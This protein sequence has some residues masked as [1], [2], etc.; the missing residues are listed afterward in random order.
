MEQRETI[1]VKQ[2]AEI[3]GCKQP[4]VHQYLHKGALHKAP[5]A[6]NNGLTHVFYDEV[7]QL[8]EKREA[9]KEHTEFGRHRYTGGPG[10]PFDVR[11][12]LDPDDHSGLIHEWYI[13]KAAFDDIN[14]GAREWGK[15]PPDEIYLE[16]VRERLP[17]PKYHK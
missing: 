16:I 7:M 8:K 2:A 6:T 15:I 9:R 14:T 3:L 13:S 12:I 4:G 1:T 17:M 10:C 11:V 5:K